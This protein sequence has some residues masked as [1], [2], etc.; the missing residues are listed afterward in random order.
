VRHATGQIVD[1]VS[2][3][4]LVDVVAKGL[5]AVDHDHGRLCLE[6][7]ANDL[8]DHRVEPILAFL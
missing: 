8:V 5:G 3:R 6:A 4:A 1:R 2:E 7:P